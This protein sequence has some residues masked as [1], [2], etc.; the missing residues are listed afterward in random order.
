MRNRKNKNSG[1]QARLHRKF[2]LKH[3]SGRGRGKKKVANHKN[4]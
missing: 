1:R 4:R 3:R 2:K